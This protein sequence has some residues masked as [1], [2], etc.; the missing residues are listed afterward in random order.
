MWKSAEIGSQNRSE[1]KM[2]FK[3]YKDNFKTT[4]TENKKTTLQDHWF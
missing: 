1:G 4:M 2:Y 3:T